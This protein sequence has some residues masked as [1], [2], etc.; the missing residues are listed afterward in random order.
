M[1]IAIAQMNATVGDLAGNAARIADFAE[2]ARRAQINFGPAQFHSGGFVDPSLAGVP[3]GWNGM[4][5][6]A[7]GEVPAILQGG[8]YVMKTSTVRRVG[9]TSQATSTPRSRY[10]RH[11]ARSMA[12]V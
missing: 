2:R 1:K 11:L 6:H 3:S 12:R 10:S 7:G 5:F 8:E 9:R 4:R